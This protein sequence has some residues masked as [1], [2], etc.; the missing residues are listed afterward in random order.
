MVAIDMQVSEVKA[1]L[2]QLVVYNGSSYRLTA[3]ILRH[4]KSGKLRYQL[5]LSDTKARS[6]LI[7]PMHEVE[8]QDV[9]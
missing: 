1:N 2:G 8:V 7:V 3:Y 6:V 5:E 4:D 9:D